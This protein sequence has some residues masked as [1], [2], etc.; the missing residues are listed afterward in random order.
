MAETTQHECDFVPLARAAGGYDAPL[1]RGTSATDRRAVR[2][3]LLIVEIV[4]SGLH[5][6]A[7]L[8]GRRL[9]A[10]VDPEADAGV[11]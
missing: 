10:V 6:C 5:C 2:L 3:R 11:N 9:P 4:Y 8:A 7:G 1:P